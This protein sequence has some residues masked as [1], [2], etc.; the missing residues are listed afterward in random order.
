MVITN[1]KHVHLKTR[2]TSSAKLSAIQSRYVQKKVKTSKYE[3]N[4]THQMLHTTQD[5]NKTSKSNN[6]IFEIF[7][8]KPNANPPS[9][10][11]ISVNSKPVSTEIELPSV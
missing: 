5:S 1:Q 9:K 10:M 3:T 7:Q 6:D 8:L 4:Q 11:E 2:S